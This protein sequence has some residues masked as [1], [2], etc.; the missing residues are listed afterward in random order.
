L[1]STPKK[2]IHDRI[3]K[4]HAAAGEARLWFSAPA[5]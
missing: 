2:I 5:R 4:Y 3:E 1:R